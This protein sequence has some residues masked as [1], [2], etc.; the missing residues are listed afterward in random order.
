MKYFQAY[1][2][3][4]CP[5]CKKA[6]DII[7]RHDKMVVVTVLDRAPEEVIADIKGQLN[8]QTVPII[9]EADTEI[10]IRM[11]G[12]CTELAAEF[13]VKEAEFEEIERKVDDEW[14]AIRGTD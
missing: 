5:F 11:I 12:G 1:V 8:H 14:D 7:E 9:L 4:G 13:N 3:T 6:L 2:K 10:G